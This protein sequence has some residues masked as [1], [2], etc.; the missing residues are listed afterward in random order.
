MSWGPSQRAMLEAMGYVLDR[1]APGGAAAGAPGAATS[2]VTS[3]PGPSPAVASSGTDDH[4]RLLLA[5]RRAAGGRD[6]AGVTLPP[7]ARLRGD[8]AAKRA[9]WPRLRALRR[10]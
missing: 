1:F 9:L 10:S 4:A 8:A 3:S 7:L 6:L 2:R 5:L